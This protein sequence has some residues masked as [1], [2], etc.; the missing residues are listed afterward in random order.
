MAAGKYNFTIEQG[1]TLDFEVCYKD[2]CN[3]P[4]DLSYYSGRMQFRSNF[5]DNTGS[6]YLTL[7][8]SRDADGTGLNFSGSTGTKA[9]TEGC[10]GI[11]AS[12]TKTEGLV[13]SQSAC[14]TGGRILYDLELYSG[15][16][17][18]YTIRL[19]QGQ[20][21]ICKEVTRF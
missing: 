4:V 18:P 12:S 13:L 16:N 20:V 21:N 14:T 2:N 11:F 17:P 1:A 19:I 8:S 15:S 10:I 7:S 9:P 6:I 5:A 3:N